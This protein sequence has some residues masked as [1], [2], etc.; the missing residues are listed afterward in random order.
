MVYGY[1]LWSP[2]DGRWPGARVGPLQRRQ[3]G[4]MTPSPS[5]LGTTLATQVKHRLSIWCRRRRS[6]ASP[7]DG[8]RWHGLYIFLKLEYERRSSNYE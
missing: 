3:P 7:L 6:T 4:P 1:G 8:C 2:A 5:P